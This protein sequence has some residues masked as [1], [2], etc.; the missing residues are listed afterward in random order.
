MHVTNYTIALISHLSNMKFDLEKVYADQCLE[1]GSEFIKNVDAIAPIVT[2]E[3]RSIMADY[4]IAPREAAYGRQIRVGGKSKTLWD[5]LLEKELKLDPE[6]PVGSNSGPVYI[7]RTGGSAPLT[8]SQKVSLDEISDVSSKELWAIA[9][10][11]KETNNFQGYERSI[12]ASVAKVKGRVG[13]VP[14]GKQ[15]AQA[16]RLRKEAIKMG[17]KFVQNLASYCYFGSNYNFL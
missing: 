2:E 13:G 9:S 6:L 4:D 10:W 16:V 3:I 1:I 17:F 12:L 15:A 11:A 8:D 5:I 7:G 14:S